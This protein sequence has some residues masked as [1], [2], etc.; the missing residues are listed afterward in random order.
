MM[1]PTID[2]PGSCE[3]RAVIRFIHAKNVSIAEILLKLF[4]VY[5]QNIM[6]EGN[7]RQWCRTCRVGEQMHMM[8]SEVVGRL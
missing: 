5:C 6:S 3:I 1:Y 7:I 2:N 4:A 8:M